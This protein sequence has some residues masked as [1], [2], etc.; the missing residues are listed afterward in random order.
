MSEEMQ[1]LWIAKYSTPYEGGD[2]LGIFTS[3]VKAMNACNK[4]ENTAS[5][6]QLAFTKY[7]KDSHWKSEGGDYDY[8]IEEIEIDK[9]CC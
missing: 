2:V 4:H 6:N 7:R 8:I 9:E 5:D 1:K 3:V